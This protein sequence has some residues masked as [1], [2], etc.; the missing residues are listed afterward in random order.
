MFFFDAF[1]MPRGVRKEVIF[2][3][4]YWNTFTAEQKCWWNTG[5]WDRYFYINY[6]KEEQNG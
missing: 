6:F 5:E 2:K 4:N 1:Q 3:S